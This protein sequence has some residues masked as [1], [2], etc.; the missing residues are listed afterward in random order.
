MGQ[1]CVRN[2]FHRMVILPTLLSSFN[3]IFFSL[4]IPNPHF[5]FELHILTLFSR[6]LTVRI[7]NSNPNF[8]GESERK[9]GHCHRKGAGTPDSG[10]LVSAPLIQINRQLVRSICAFLKTGLIKGD[11]NWLNFFR[12]I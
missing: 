12:I 8:K 1:S 5:S 9:T 4:D 7:V 3:P 2:R 10:R 11:F 6:V